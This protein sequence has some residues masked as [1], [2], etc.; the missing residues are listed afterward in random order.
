[1]KNADLEYPKMLKFVL[2]REGEYE[3][4]KTERGGRCRLGIP[5][6]QQIVH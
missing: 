3:K 4:K 2:A 1:M 6:Q 5:A